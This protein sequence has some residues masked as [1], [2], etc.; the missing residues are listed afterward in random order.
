MIRRLFVYLFFI[1]TLFFIVQ[2]HSEFT[3][4][5]QTVKT[6]D[7]AWL[8]VALIIQFIYLLSYGWLL[9]YVLGIVGIKAKA[10]TLARTFCESLTI[11]TVTPTGGFGGIAYLAYQ[12]TKDSNSKGKDDTLKSSAA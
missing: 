12:A 5:L 8:G 9:K 11:N 6:S 2:H 4:Q 3:D 10:R 1:A 7:F